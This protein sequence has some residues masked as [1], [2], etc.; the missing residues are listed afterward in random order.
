MSGLS[1][2]IE[3][4]L[5]RLADN[6]RTEQDF[7][8]TLSEALR[9]VDEQ[10][11]R[12]VRNVSLQHELRREAILGELQELATRLCAL[13]VRGP[14]VPAIDQQMMH[15]GHAE[16]EPPMPPSGADWRQATQN[17]GDEFDFSFNAPRH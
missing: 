14:A 15:Q 8:Q 16:I 6:A 17:I 1:K 13:P 12:D 11:L 7:V 5:S 10:L 4:M 2:N 3:E 9:R